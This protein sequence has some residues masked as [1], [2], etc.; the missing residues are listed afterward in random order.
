[1]AELSTRLGAV[2]VAA[3]KIALDFFKHGTKTSASVSYKDG[4]SP[5]SEADLAVDRFLREQL[6]PLAPDAGWLSEESTDDP[7]RL[8]RQRVMVVDPI[9]GTRAFIN[10]DRRW[11]IAIALVEDGRPVASALHMPALDELFLAAAGHGATRNGIALRVSQRQ[12]LTGAT[13]GGPKKALEAMERRGVG[14]IP[15]NRVPSLAYRLARV[16]SA[17]VDAALASTNAWDWDIAA[18]DLII[19]E[20]GGLLTGLDGQQ[21]RYNLPRPRHGILA[22]AGP[23]LHPSLV[24]AVRAIMP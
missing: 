18:A 1:M 6:T 8:K 5:V 21:P 22:A 15:E 12:S 16:A 24:A 11:G 14:A 13:I 9:D 7:E 4:G 10:G 3:G 19:G 23:R 2:A 20:S 17:D